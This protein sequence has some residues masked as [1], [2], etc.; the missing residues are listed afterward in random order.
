MNARAV[1]DPDDDDDDDP[2]PGLTNR[3]IALWSCSTMLL[4]Y[5]F[6]RNL[7]VWVLIW[8]KNY[9]ETQDRP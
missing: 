6:C 1:N 4:R 2:I 8:T 5:L 3:F 7:T 9:G